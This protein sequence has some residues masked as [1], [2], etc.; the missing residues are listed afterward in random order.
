M[1][2]KLSEYK[3]RH[4]EWQSFS[5]N[6]MSFSN[7]LLLTISIAYFGYVFE[8]G[9]EIINYA[10]IDF[11]HK[12]SYSV[13]S[14]VASLVLSFIS[15]LSGVIVMFSRLYDFRISR[16]IAYIRYKIYKSFRKPL[17]EFKS[18]TNFLVSIK[19]LFVIFFSKNLIIKKNDIDDFII[20]KKSFLKKFEELSLISSG[21]ADVT[22]KFT[23]LQVIFLFLSLLVFTIH[24]MI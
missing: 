18:Q 6:Q 22:W 5:L 17:P 19:N 13:I 1:N 2:D 20:D 21:L 10:Y 7:N 8:T 12:I 14:Y 23:K 11:E 9:H 24:L 3:S 16:N 15:L 4:K